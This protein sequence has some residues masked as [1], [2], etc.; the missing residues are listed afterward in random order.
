V[1]RHNLTR[2]NLFRT[3]AATSAAAAAV[4][5]LS[6]CKHE[7]DSDLTSDPV[8]VEEDSATT[9][10]GEDGAYDYLDLEFPS[11]GQ[12]EL[13]LGN[14]LHEGEGTWLPVTTA[15]AS[16]MPMIKCSAFSLTSGELTEVVPAPITPNSPNV[17]IYDAR[18]SDSTYA[19][20]ELDTLTKSW[21]LY[22]GK[23][24]DGVLSGSPNTLWEADADW[25]PPRFAVTGNRVIWQVMPSL[26]GKKTSEMSHCYL[27]K[28]G[29]ANATDV[30][31][32]LGRFA[33]APSVSGNTVT[34]APRVRND[35]GT[36]YGITAYSLSDDM[37]TMI[38][39][40]VM[41]EN[42]RPFHAVR[43]GDV[44]ALSVEASYGY[45]GLLG[46]MGTYIGTADGNFASVPLEPFANIAGSKDGIFVVKS[47]ASYYVVDIKQRGYTFLGAADRCV[48]YGEYP[49]RVGETDM[50]VTYSTIKNADTGYPASVLVRAFDL[51]GTQ[52]E[53]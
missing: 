26:S 21:A 19:W 36:Y 28:T 33:T 35:E 8:V 1:L 4:H 3:V 50:F 11:L 10:L 41:P 30:V 49:A 22:A 12:W 14:V 51:H 20:V 42:V 37:E 13:P 25:D 40:L 38:D 32:S 7:A 27:W 34:L 18:C 48:D 43:M 47:R 31:E 52:K 6:G 16:A 53:A 15:G 9:V 39:R 29:S 17:V 5:V 46:S 45:G 24:A 44:F 2:R 23:F